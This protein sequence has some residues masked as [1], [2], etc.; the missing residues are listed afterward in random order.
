MLQP[1][2]QKQ[3]MM[4]QVGAEVLDPVVARSLVVD[5]PGDENNL[6]RN[7]SSMGKGGGVVLPM[8][9]SGETMARTTKYQEC[10]MMT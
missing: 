10:L 4:Q 7:N 1:V 8:S 5:Q 6:C 3:Q 2:T 9:I